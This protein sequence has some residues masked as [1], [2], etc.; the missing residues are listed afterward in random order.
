MKVICLIF[1]FVTNFAFASSG[2][3]ENGR[4]LFS[5][6]KNVVNEA[7][8]KIKLDSNLEK[9]LEFEIKNN[10]LDE[11]SLKVMRVL[12]KVNL[13]PFLIKN[14]NK[15]DYLI[16]ATILDLINDSNK[17]IVF[18]Y[19]NSL[20]KE[21]SKISAARKIVLLRF[22]FINNYK[23]NKNEIKNILNDSSYEVRMNFAREI[24]LKLKSGNSLFVENW[25]EL[26]G[27]KPFQVRLEALEVLDYVDIKMA[28]QLNPFLQSCLKDSNETVA[29]L[30][31]LQFE[32]YK[33]N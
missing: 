17:K 24:S 25:K 11:T 8:K 29:K 19:F 5:E 23:F 30:C 12:K 31:Q 10:K 4:L 28:Q 26:I 27:S 9:D 13:I 1:L 18:D 14:K 6:D 7:L 16:D 33:R 21:Y 3:K 32:R 15:N 20:K 22:L 2:W